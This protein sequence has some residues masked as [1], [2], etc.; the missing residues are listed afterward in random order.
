MVVKRTPSISSKRAIIERTQKYWS[1]ECLWQSGELEINFDKISKFLFNEYELIPE[2]ERI[3]KGRVFITKSVVEGSFNLLEDN[4]CIDFIEYCTMM[5]D[6]AELKNNNFLRIFSL[7]MIA[8]SS[9]ISRK[10]LEKGLKHIYTKFANH[11]NWEMREISAYTIREGLRIFPEVTLSIL[12]EWIS[13]KPNA[14][15]RRLIA[16][17]LRPMADIK[18]LRDPAKNDPIIEILIKLKA[19]ESEYV[20][21]SV[22]NNFKDLSKYMP[23]KI[24]DLTEN[25]IQRANITVMNDLA[26]K[27]KQDLGEENYYL[28]WTIK[29]GLRWLKAKNPEYHARI[30][31]ILGRNYVLYFNE[32]KNRSAKPR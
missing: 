31:S 29:H 26:S 11:T 1:E 6:Y 12:N 15:I 18:W 16:E 9:T 13:N 3:G 28:I 4:F 23:E 27:T 7:L 20:R 30:T 21:K 25:M 8:K 24:L 32:K 2:K 5:F 10:T 14:N 22:G 19:D 17:S